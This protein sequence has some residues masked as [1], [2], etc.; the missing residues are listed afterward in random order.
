MNEVAVACKNRGLR[1]F[2]HVNRVHVAP[3]CT[4][5][6]DQV[7]EGLSILDGALKVADS[8]YSG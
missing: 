3:P 1:P 5:T 4:V 8:Y 6:A 2:T 7:R